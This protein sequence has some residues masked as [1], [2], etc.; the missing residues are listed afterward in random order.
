MSHSHESWMNDHQEG[1]GSNPSRS[2]KAVKAAA[3]KRKTGLDGKKRWG[4]SSMK[5]HGV[6]SPAMM[7][8]RAKFNK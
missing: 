8:A 1:G 6:N 3:L 5:G 4:N 7:E 2:A